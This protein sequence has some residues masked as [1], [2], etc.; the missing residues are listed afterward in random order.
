LTD[1]DIPT[2]LLNYA[3][4]YESVREEPTQE[5]IYS[6]KISDNG[7]NLPTILKLDRFISPRQILLTLI[8]WS[9]FKNLSF[10]NKKIKTIVLYSITAMKTF[11]GIAPPPPKKVYLSI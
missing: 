2:S 10:P 4:N 1:S 9:N 8:K 7:V 3:S 6:L 5:I 11:K